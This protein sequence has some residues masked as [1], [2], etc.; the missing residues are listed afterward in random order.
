MKKK[1]QEMTK[2]LD[3]FISN[4]K[5]KRASEDDSINDL[6]E[7]YIRKVHEQN[8]AYFHAKNK[9]LKERRKAMDIK[10]PKGL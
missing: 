4:S 1:V 8:K 6:L 10:F 3:H 7:N 2:K 9:E 5:P